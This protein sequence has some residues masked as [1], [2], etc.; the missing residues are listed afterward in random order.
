MLVL[1]SCEKFA[2][3]SLNPTKIHDHVMAQKDKY[4]H[5][6]HQPRQWSLSYVIHALSFRPS[7][8]TA[9]ATWEKMLMQ[10]NGEGPTSS[11]EY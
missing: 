9:F 7:F 6:M 1:V 5:A 3:Q 10:Q 4:S 2:I 8:E 11:S